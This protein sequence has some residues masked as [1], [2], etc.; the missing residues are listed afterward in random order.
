MKSLFTKAVHTGDRKKAGPHIPVTT[1]IYTAASYFYESTETLDKIFGHEMH[2][3]SYARYEN[4]TN[5]ALEEVAAALENG[6]GALACA[7]GMAALQTA[8]LVA[9]LDRNRSIVAASDMYG[10]TINLL[11]KILDPLGISVRFVNICDLAAIEAAIVETKAGCLVMETVSNPILRVGELDKIAAIAKKTN[12]AVIVDNT[13][14]TPLLV[15]P[16]ELGASFSVHSATKY[17]SGHGDVLGGLIVADEEH[18]EPLRAYSRIAGPVMGPF[19]AYLTMRGIKTFPLRMERQCQN[20]CRVANWLATHPRVDK[21]FFT[22]D[23]KHPDAETIARMFPK[24]LFGAIVSFEIKDAG[25]QDIFRFMDAL[26]ML[27]RATSLGD[28]HSMALYPL[29]AS[30]RDLPPK[31]RARMGI[32][33]NLVRI[34]VGIEAAEDIIAD[35]DQAL[36]N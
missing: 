4:P 27:V 14:S 7:S 33:D 16:I 36:Q 18:I 15:R 31:Q 22:G 2:G 20:A 25:K 13:F 21:V 19:E 28:V 34:S 8:I 12:T 26:K 24:N 6:A 23:P 35:I 17:L 3:Q 29:I 11:T 32:K 1:P 5:A 30:H 10:A 9:L